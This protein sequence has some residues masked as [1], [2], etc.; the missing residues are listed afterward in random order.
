MVT[1][2]R[3]RFRGFAALVGLLCALAFGGCTDQSSPHAFTSYWNAF[4]ASRESTAPPFI[5][6]FS[7][8]I[9]EAWKHGGVG[10]TC[11][12]RCMRGDAGIRTFMCMKPNTDVTF[13]VFIPLRASLETRSVL[14]TDPEL[15][16]DCDI[17]FSIRIES[18]TV[19]RVVWS[20][21]LNTKNPGHTGEGVRVEI[22]L[23][24]FEGQRVRMTFACDRR[25]L[26]CRGFTAAFEEPVLRGIMGRVSDP[27]SAPAET[28]SPEPSQPP[29]N[30]IVFLEDTLRPDFTGAYGDPLIHTPAFDRLAA[31]GLQYTTCYSTSSWT[32]PAVA[33]I[34]TGLPAYLHDCN[35]RD[36]VLNESFETLPERLASAGYT[37]VGMTANGNTA[38][39]FGVAQGYHEYHLIAGDN[40][41]EQRAENVVNRVIARLEA[42][43]QEPFFLYV[44]TVDP[45]DPY[46]PPSP[47]DRL[48][49]TAPTPGRPI[50]S[51]YMADVLRRKHT[52]PQEELDYIREQ[53][54]GEIA[55]HDRHFARILRY[56][57]SSGL[58]RR[59]VL[60]V[61]ADHGEQFF[62]HGGMIHGTTLFEEECRVP[63][64]FYSGGTHGPDL[65]DRPV[66]LGQIF[67]TYL[68]A[69]GLENPS[70]KSNPASGRSLWKGIT[71]GVDPSDRMDVPLYQELYLD[72]IR[73]QASR[74]R[75]FTLTRDL[76]APNERLFDRERDPGERENRV[77][78]NREIHRSMRNALDEWLREM[79][80]A[81]VT[82]SGRMGELDEATR[83]N[84]RRLGY[85]Q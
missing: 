43:L 9:A 4:S 67:D 36:D 28:A 47:Y 60:C 37:C 27:A 39:E 80:A 45:H 3:H 41:D 63:M 84:L 74:T 46:T 65:S 58:S 71:E 77:S 34:L 19:S 15:S 40:P 26:I 51:A 62:E 55:Y 10:E 83:E 56:L 66:N 52:P 53:Y 57:E 61:I 23:T 42:G 50:D 31:R 16:L 82:E 24:V 18:E 6:E 85:L 12:V 75:Q 76:V 25:T 73:K 49:A 38:A 8:H 14:L 78:D 44:H 2:I 1:A 7:R 32:R 17:V 35:N 21:V 68:E 29:P 20:S 64:V 11:Y 5:F 13:D 69:A 30:L 33:S 48:Y 72:G 70:S 54:R 81:R 79:A 59:S 22:D